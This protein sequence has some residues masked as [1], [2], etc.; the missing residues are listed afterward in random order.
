MIN[1]FN[2]IFIIFK[3]IIPSILFYIYTRF[4][5]SYINIPYFCSFISTFFLA[6]KTLINNIFFDIKYNKFDF[7]FK[8][9]IYF[10][11]HSSDCLFEHLILYFLTLFHQIIIETIADFIISDKMLIDY[12]I[13][14]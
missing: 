9:V 7:N 8:T 6:I 1:D 14:F 3:N 11:C 4:T 5:K 13:F 2:N 10:I 12:I